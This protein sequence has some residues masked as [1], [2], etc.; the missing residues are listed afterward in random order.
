VTLTVTSPTQ[1][2][3]YLFR[4]GA[5]L[6]VVAQ[7]FPDRAIDALTASYPAKHS[8]HF[9]LDNV[10]ESFSGAITGCC[11]LGYHAA[12]AGPA[13]T[14]KTWIYAAYSEPGTFVNNVIV[15]VQ[16]LS[17]ELAESLNDPFVGGLAFLNFIPPAVLRGQG[18]ASII[19]FE[20]GDPLERPPKPFTQVTNGTTYHL[21]DEVF[22]PWYLHTAP[23]FSVNGWYTLRN[24]FP[25][26]SWLC[27]PG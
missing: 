16:A 4:S 6:G 18:G 13:V 8:A 26:F 10:F 15:G 9:L 11:I 17:H 24:T 22:L 25:A 19:N 7:S 20:T 3:L 27:G 5:L 2:N 1:G 23:S 12:Q 14:A 21:Q